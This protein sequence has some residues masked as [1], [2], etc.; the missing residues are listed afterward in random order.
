MGALTLSLAPV[1]YTG[2]ALVVL[3][4]AFFYPVWTAAGLT[5]ADHAM[6]VWVDTP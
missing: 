4:F 2:V 3:C 6:R 5:P 1:A